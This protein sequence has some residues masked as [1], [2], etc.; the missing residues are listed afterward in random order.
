MRWLPVILVSLYLLAPV[1]VSAQGIVPEPCTPGV[2]GCPYVQAEVGRYGTCE[3][4]QLINNVISFLVTFASIAAVL[5]IIYGGFQLVVSAGNVSAKQA[6]KSILVNTLIGYVIILAAFLIVNTILGV[7]LPSGSPALGWQR[8]ECLYPTV[9]ISREYAEYN[10][11]E[12]ISQ[13]A[14]G[15][16][17]TADARG[18]VAGD[19][20]PASFQS[21]GA[22]AQEA[23]IFSCLSRYESGCNLAAQ[24]PWSSAR[25]VLQIV[26]GLNNDC[27]NLNNSTC[28]AAAQ[29]A[30]FTVSGNLNCSQ[31]FTGGTSA[32]NPSRARPGQEDLFEACNAAAANFECNVTAARCLTADDSYADWA[33]ADNQRACILNNGGRI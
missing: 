27:H 25:G 7:L 5:L 11:A 33:V 3:F 6:A 1:M 16:V 17:Y 24:N 4:V 2:A 20:S 14:D 31:A 10:P 23:A 18:Y 15:T 22:T 26:R 28:T 8:I 30:G 32:S 13:R 9:S 21:A 19:C 12:F 29:R